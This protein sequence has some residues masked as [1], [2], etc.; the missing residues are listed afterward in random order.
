MR[1][2][3][4]G[5]LLPSS[6]DPIKDREAFLKL[7]TMDEEG[8]KRRQTKPIPIQSLFDYCS[9]SERNLFFDLSSPRPRLKRGMAASDREILQSMAFS[10]MPYS[11]KLD[12]CLRPEQM[13]GPSDEVWVWFKEW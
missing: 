11:K 10:R 13:D 9:E 2:A 6:D 7:M 8:L 3:L 4:L 5:M 12:F 1:A